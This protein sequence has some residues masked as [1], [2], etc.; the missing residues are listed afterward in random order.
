MSQNDLKKEI[1]QNLRKYHSGKWVAPP[2]AALGL[3]PKSFEAVRELIA[4]R[5]LEEKHVYHNG[6][7]AQL[8][9]YCEPLEK[10]ILKVINGDK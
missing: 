10:P 9:R 1:I 6:F 3:S 8:V 5:V 4:D 2:I 7:N